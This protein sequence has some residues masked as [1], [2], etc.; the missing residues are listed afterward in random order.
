MVYNNHIF[1]VED[2][3]LKVKGIYVGLPIEELT[4]VLLEQGFTVADNDSSATVYGGSIEGLGICC[5]SIRE[6]NNKVVS[7]IIRTVR[8]CTEDEALAV[9]EQV[10]SD[11]H[12]EPGFDYN[13]YGITPKPHEIDHF[14]DLNEG[15]LKIQWDGF[16]AHGFS[17][18]DSDGLDYISFGLQGPVVK[19]EAYWRSEV[20]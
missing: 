8:K 4:Q 19:D 16:N 14:W 15:L 13:G 2:G 7:I 11:L 6:A 18:R 12:K 9:F 20:D 17:F 3:R 1:I 5:L 10:K